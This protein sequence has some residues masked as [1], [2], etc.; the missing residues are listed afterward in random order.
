MPTYYYIYKNNKIL[1]LIEDCEKSGNFTEVEK[2][3]ET[4]YKCKCKNNQ[5]Y[6]C[7]YENECDCNNEELRLYN[8]LSHSVAYIKINTLKYFYHKIKLDYS[9]D[10]NV[11][12]LLHLSIK[13]YIDAYRINKNKD[14][15]K[16]NFDFDFDMNNDELL[17]FTEIYEEKEINEDLIKKIVDII[18]ILIN[19][20]KEQNKNINPMFR[21]L[22]PLC[23]EYSDYDMI[24]LLC[25]EHELNIWDLYHYSIAWGYK[26]VFDE[27]IE[28]FD[29]LIEYR[30]TEHAI[31]IAY[32]F[33]NPDIVNHVMEKLKIKHNDVYEKIKHLHRI[34]EYIYISNN[35][36]PENTKTLKF[37]FNFNEPIDNIILTPNIKKIIFNPYFNQSIDNVKF[38]D[39]LEELYFG[40]ENNWSSF[41]KSIMNVKFPRTLKKYISRGKKIDDYEIIKNNGVFS[42][43]M[44]IL[45]LGY[46]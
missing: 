7:D 3:I 26:D 40:T 5:D 37:P 38:P 13:M 43:N 30:W 16:D 20:Q 10:G 31:E 41:N 32:R 35:P 6:D 18:S 1:H 33:D 46:I 36:I 25:R 24:N 14:K 28:R 17:Y 4:N 21:D 23:K 45:N 19:S 11:Y 27:L 2:Y 34:N 22:I 15:N 8:I 9:R 12:D 29:D 39:T 42:E 44:E